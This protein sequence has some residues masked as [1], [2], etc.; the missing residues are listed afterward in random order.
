MAD[1]R[2]KNDALDK[3]LGGLGSEKGHGKQTPGRNM[4]DDEQFG[5][6]G[7]RQG[8]SERIEDDEDFD[9]KRSGSHG[10]SQGRRQ[11]GQNR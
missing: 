7:G 10:S 11:G 6:K 1:D 4:E 5:Q 2:M 9:S 3:N 8:M